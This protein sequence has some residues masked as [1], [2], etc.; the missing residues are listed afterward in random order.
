MYYV[1][2]ERRHKIHNPYYA[3]SKIKNH[4]LDKMNTD[5]LCRLKILCIM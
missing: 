3:E 4:E 1:I 2:S 5:E